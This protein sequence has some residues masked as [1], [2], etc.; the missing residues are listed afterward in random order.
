MKLELIK[1]SI[2][3]NYKNIF[4]VNCDLNINLNI[5]E[6]IYFKSF[7]ACK[8]SFKLNIKLSTRTLNNYNSQMFKRI[9]SIIKIIE[10][11]KYFKNALFCYGDGT[12][13]LRKQSIT[14][15]SRHDFYILIPDSY[16]VESHGY[17]KILHSL[18]N[19][20]KIKS[21]IAY[22]VGGV[23]GLINRL[24]EIR[25]RGRIILHS[26]KE[27]DI[28]KCNIS[29]NRNFYINSPKEKKIYE[30]FGNFFLK[31]HLNEHYRVK[32]NQMYDYL[33]QVDVD[34]NTNSFEG[35]F[36]KLYS[37]RPL[38]K[39]RSSYGY[40]QWYYDRLKPDYHYFDVKSDLSN[41]REKYN[42]ALEQSKT[43]KVFPGREFISKMNY[44]EELQLAADKISFY[45]K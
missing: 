3:E 28:L 11:S 19:L 5:D 25:D 12:Y 6:K 2:L 18:K 14:F 43:T 23:N 45:F 34:G 33:I 35:F 32:I 4:K 36:H 38:L 16:Y 26:L 44:D 31:N 9:A 7:I 27:I 42:E 15:C 24:Y 10:H 17:S 1:K 21:E 22:F 20:N 29:V 40:K 8:D 41:F 37:G 13:N 39:I 30:I